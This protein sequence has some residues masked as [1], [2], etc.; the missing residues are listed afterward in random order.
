MLLSARDIR[1][2]V[3]RDEIHLRPFREELLKPA[4]YVLTLGTGWLKWSEA[5]V[6]RDVWSEPTS[7]DLQ[8]EHTDGLFLKNGTFMLARTA[9]TIGLNFQIAGLLGSLSHL[10]R[11][12]ISVTQ[13]SFLVSP[14]YGKTVPTPLTLEI[15]S[16]NPS[17]VRI[18]LGTPICQIAFARVSPG[19][20]DA[21]LLSSVYEGIASPTVRSLASEFD[22]N[23]FTI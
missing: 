1:N 3:S 13:G 23:L 19:A 8:V 21:S 11:F 7:G 20:E 10:A 9:E 2:A 18:P 15:Y 17:P 6:A 14:G 16:V 4:S 12:G 22:P 5:S